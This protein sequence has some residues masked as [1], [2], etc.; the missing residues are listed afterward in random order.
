MWGLL[1]IL[2]LQLLAMASADAANG[3]NNPSTATTACVLLKDKDRL[4]FDLKNVS[5]TIFTCKLACE[6]TPTCLT[7]AW[8]NFQGGTCWLKSRAGK[9]I[10]KKGVLTTNC[11]RDLPS[12]VCN[13][14]ADMEFVGN[15]L[16]HRPGSKFKNCCDVCNETLGC[17]AYSWSDHQGGTCWLKK[18]VDRAIRKRGVVSSVTVPLESPLCVTEAD[19]EFIG[20]DLANIPATNADACC[21]VC[22]TYDG[23]K[24]YSW[25]TENGGTC[26]LKKGKGRAM[27]AAGIISAALA[28]V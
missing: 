21:A 18:A 8:S 11:V 15:D 17:K 14:F 28:S 19:T 9:V 25:T 1:I 5:G 16:T 12:P 24:A 3:N 2:M 26:W 20:N 7:W 10:S 13:I 27:P 6:R 4:G 22:K 23:C